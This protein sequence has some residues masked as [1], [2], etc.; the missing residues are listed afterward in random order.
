MAKKNEVTQE[1]LDKNPDSKL[2]VGDSIPKELAT[3][4][5]PLADL[6]K[7]SE[8]L[9]ELERKD[10]ERD[11]EMEGLRQM[12]E[13]KAGTV[14]EKV[15]REK[16][17]FEPKFRTVRLRKFP[18]AGDVNDM[19]YIVGWD[20]R[21]AYEEVDR[22][23]IAPQIVN[24][25]NVI[26]LGR[27]RNSDGVLQAEKVKLLDIFNKGIQTHCKILEMQ[28]TPRKE[29]TG[30]E[31]DVTVFDPQHGLVS[32]GEKVDGYVTFS[33]RKYKLQV[34]GVAEAVWIDA[35]YCN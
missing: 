30:E 19:G 6:T 26:F 8:Q 2:A 18:V 17:D 15:L 31:I 9:A 21:G 28:I 12:A 20:N 16:K 1:W 34:P 29:P 13:E 5:V 7:M 35:T 33:D 25:I 24:Y 10:A 3:V 11:A 22:S 32:T 27:E 14:G 4:E 23:G